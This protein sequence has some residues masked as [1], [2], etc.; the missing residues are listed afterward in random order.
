MIADDRAARARKRHQRFPPIVS[1]ADALP[2]TNI[3]LLEQD[4]LLRE[5][6]LSH[7]TMAEQL[8]ALF[9]SIPAAPR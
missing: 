4:T 2:L 3:E 5:A 9:A 7:P 6:I 1:L 8:N